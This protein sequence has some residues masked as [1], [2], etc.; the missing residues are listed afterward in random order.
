MQ[1]GKRL[2]IAKYRFPFFFC[3][4]LISVSYGT[5]ATGVAVYVFCYSFLLIYNETCKTV[6]HIG[7]VFSVNPKDLNVPE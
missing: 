7:F 6:C 1:K 4:G 5:L 3:Q 2:S